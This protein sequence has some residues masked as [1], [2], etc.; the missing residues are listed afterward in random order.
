[1]QKSMIGILVTHSGDFH[2][3]TLT[4]AITG[5]RRRND[6][7][8]NQAIKAEQWLADYPFAQTSIEIHIPTYLSGIGP[9]NV[10]TGYGPGGAAVGYSLFK[11]GSSASG[12]QIIINNGIKAVYRVR[13][14]AGACMKIVGVLKVFASTKVHHKLSA[15]LF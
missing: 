3:P 2:Q 1:F 12:T 4:A 8:K 7:G 6:R 5:H 9:V 10:A 13:L 15:S 11:H 14:G